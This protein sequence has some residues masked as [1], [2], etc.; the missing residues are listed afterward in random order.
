MCQGV[1]DE[2]VVVV[3]PAAGEGMATYQRIKLPERDKEVKGEGRNMES[4]NRRT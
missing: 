4:S 1:A 2:V 3:K